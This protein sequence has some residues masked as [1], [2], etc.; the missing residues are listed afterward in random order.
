M[1]KL[2]KPNLIL[3]IQDLDKVID[4]S[5]G[6]LDEV[7]KTGLE[8]LYCMYD[9]A[10]GE[11]TE[12]EHNTFD[13]KKAAEVHKL[14]RET[15][16]SGTGKLKYIRQELLRNV[17]KCPYCGFGEPVT[18]DHYKPES[19]YKALSVCRL[20]LVPMCYRCNNLKGI[21]DKFIHPYYQEFPTG[22]KF[23]VA[24]VTFEFGYFLFDFHIDS[25]YLDSQLE[26][27]LEFQI[28]K[29][30]LSERLNREAVTMVYE[31]LTDPHINNDEEMLHLYV[32]NARNENNNKFGLNHWKSVVLD[33]LL[34]SPDLNV[35]NVN[36][37]LSKMTEQECK[38]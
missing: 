37:F 15:Y 17:C 4:A 29:I 16:K 20:N 24:S 13:S 12:D 7:D 28:S 5:N 30:Q 1:W 9:D 31:L 14:Y 23:F 25:G 8:I 22:V 21:K 6:E 35:E 27:I 10:K 32:E 3:A 33:A 36:A 34:K 11:L 18:L 38:V 19:I 2:N 26:Q